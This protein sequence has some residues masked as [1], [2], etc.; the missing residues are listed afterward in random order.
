MTS[1]QI[2]EA[3]ERRHSMGRNFDALQW[4]FFRELRV[5]TGFGVGREQRIDLWVMNVW[6]SKKYARIAYEVKCSRSDFLRE[7]AAP[8]KREAALAVSNEFYFAAPKGLIKPVELPMNCG[9]IE[10]DED[11]VTR[12]KFAPPWRDIPPPSIDFFATVARR[13]HRVVKL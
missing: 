10:V 11:G 12:V 1:T 3:L 5:A 7:L 4:A 6:Q 13:V 9:L 8:A 2:L